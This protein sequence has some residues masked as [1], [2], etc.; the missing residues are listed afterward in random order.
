M[1][2][3]LPTVSGGALETRRLEGDSQAPLAGPGA[4]DELAAA[5]TA[6]AWL[7]VCI[8]G[9]GAVTGVHVREASSPK[10]ARVFAAAAQ[11]WKFHPFELRGQPTPVCAM[12]QM[13]Y[14][15]DPTAKEVLPLPLPADAGAFTNVP[16]G[17]LGKPLSGT[18]V[19]VPSDSDKSRI[20]QLGVT[21]LVGAVH[22][23]VDETGHVNHTSL[24]RSTGLQD[25]DLRLLDGVRRWVYRP[26]LDDGQPVSVCSS[27][28][29]IYSQR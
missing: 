19:L 25:Y 20:A 5:K 7:K 22:Y 27:V 4:F 9:G 8:D 28:H 1:A 3:A 11:T 26:Y 17:S 24:I 16:P 6:R 10:A 12:M 23:C 21:L 18:N 13:R 29:F 15:E 2:D 14:P